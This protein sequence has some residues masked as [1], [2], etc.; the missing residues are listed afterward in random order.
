MIEI[1]LTIT[2]STTPD[3]LRRFTILVQDADGPSKVTTLGTTD[4]GD[5]YAQITSREE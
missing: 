2:E 3:E 4:D 5:L 1:S